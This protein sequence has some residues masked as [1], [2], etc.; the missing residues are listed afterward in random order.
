MHGAT[1]AM[2]RNF[3]VIN[4]N[5]QV[6]AVQPL[7]NKKTPTQG[8]RNFAQ[9]GTVYQGH[10]NFVCWGMGGLLVCAL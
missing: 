3:N 4:F 5:I 6:P 1:R 2:P 8:K 10:S 7:N 9:L